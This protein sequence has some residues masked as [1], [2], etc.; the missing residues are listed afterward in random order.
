[1]NCQHVLVAVIVTILFLSS[2]CFAS[3]TTTRVR[4]EEV[5]APAAQPQP[6]QS[7]RS[8]D[9]LLAESIKQ[10][11]HDGQ[12]AGAFAH[13]EFCSQCDK[14]QYGPR[15][16]S[17]LRS[18]CIAS[19]CNP[20]CIDMAWSVQLEV[21]CDAA[22][23]WKYCQAFK[24]QVKMAERAITSQFQAHVC[25]E[26]NFC[27]HTDEK[28]LDWVENHSYGH[29]SYPEHVIPIPTCLASLHSLHPS[30]GESTCKVCSN[31]VTASIRRGT[32]DFNSGAGYELKQ[33]TALQERCEFVADFISTHAH[34]LLL[35]LQRSVCSCL[36]CCDTEAVSPDRIDPPTQMAMPGLGDKE[37]NKARNK[38]C[39]FP[40]KDKEWMSNLIKK[41]NEN[42]TNKIHKQKEVADRKK[43][44]NGNQQ[45]IDPS[46]DTAQHHQYYHD[47]FPNFKVDL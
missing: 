33:M 13:K 37:K 27:S 14:T 26:S 44:K 1:M 46:A 43:K 17:L 42:V 35:E 34:S 12:L 39:Y 18:E 28:I 10:T 22:P 24:E 11:V 23:Q 21:D 40:N 2:S 7:I 25:M 47:S 16:C 31:I 6:T 19:F 38:E 36:G 32:C 9:E 5:A 8:I 3:I 41:V 30:V 20:V 15:L 4:D 45:G 29:N